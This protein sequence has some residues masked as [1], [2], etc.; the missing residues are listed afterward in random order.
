M[1][2]EHLR[3]GIGDRVAYMS[4]G[5]IRRIVEVTFKSED[6]KNGQAGFDGV[7]VNGPEAGT[8]VWGYDDQILATTINPDGAR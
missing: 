2:I 3:Y 4:F 7:V 8:S 5:Y 1:N 6:I